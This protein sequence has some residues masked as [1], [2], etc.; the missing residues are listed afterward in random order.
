M[1][2]MNIAWPTKVRALS[3]AVT[4]VFDLLAC[5]RVHHRYFAGIANVSDVRFEAGLKGAPASLGVRAKLLRVIRTG[6]G[7]C[8]LEQ[9]CL[10][11]IGKVLDVRFEAVSFDLASSSFAAPGHCASASFKQAPVNSADD[12]IDDGSNNMAARKRELVNATRTVM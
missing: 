3:S 10:A 8:H 9:H 11:V 7:V 6:L 4:L 12:A 5:C 2:S 1:P